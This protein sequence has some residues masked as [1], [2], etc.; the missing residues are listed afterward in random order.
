MLLVKM[1]PIQ[2]IS[3]LTISF[4]PYT[5]YHN[6]NPLAQSLS[7]ASHIGVWYDST[8]ITHFFCFED[9]AENDSATPITYQGMCQSIES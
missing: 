3:A 5:L 7:V 9:S 1:I 8:G 4:I 2:M 6:K